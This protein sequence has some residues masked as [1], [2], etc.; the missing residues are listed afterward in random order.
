M[1]NH[2]LTN[3]LTKQSLR[4]DTNSHPMS[5]NVPTPEAPKERAG[6][7][8]RSTRLRNLGIAPTSKASNQEH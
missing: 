1:N 7:E 8:Y 2:D 6:L 5:S 4:W 3:E